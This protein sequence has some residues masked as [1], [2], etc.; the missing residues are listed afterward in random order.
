MP[1]PPSQ[2]EGEAIIRPPAARDDAASRRAVIA[3]IYGE[4][5]RRIC[6]VHYPFGTILRELE[7]AGEF[8]VSRTPVREALQRLQVD[9]LVET[10]HGVGSRVIAGDRA[11]FEDI[12]ALR[13][14]ISGLMA[15][16]AP[17]PID[18]KSTAAIAELLQR[19][20]SL[21][22]SRDQQ[23][24]WEI[25]ESRHQ[26]INGLIGNRELAQL[27]DHYYHKVAPFWFGLCTRNFDLEVD[28][29]EKELQDTLF[30]MRADDMEAIASINRHYV[31]LARVRIRA[32]LGAK[33]TEAE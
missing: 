9:G 16:L 7:L 26:I 12:F 22:A 33:A 5:R 4:L 21:K 24:F 27:H 30:W 18:E 29:L 14:E 3:S 19:A 2:A 13:I 32:S 8:G 17:K 25:N 1:I 31:A 10:R 28:T 6:T 23:R 15:K 20:R 11:S